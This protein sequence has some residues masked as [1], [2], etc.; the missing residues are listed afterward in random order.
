M[1]GRR[2]EALDMEQK[3][4]A[5]SMY[6]FAAKLWAAAGGTEGNSVVSPF[7]VSEAMGLALTGARGETAA[8]IGRVILPPGVSDA[9]GYFAQ[10]NR[11]LAGAGGAGALKIANALWVNAAGTG[12]REAFAQRVAEVF[13]GMVETTEF[14]EAAVA[15][16]NRWV[17]EKTDGMIE[18]LFTPAMFAGSD[19]VLANVVCFRG[20]WAAPFMADDTWDERFTLRDGRKGVVPTMHRW[21]AWCMWGEWDEGAMLRLPYKG[22]KLEMQ[23][24]V[25]KDGVEL[26]TLERCLGADWAE[27]AKGTTRRKVDIHLPRF[28]VQRAAESL[29]DALQELGI[30]LAFDATAADFGGMGESPHVIEDVV[31]AAV[32]EVDES[33]TKAAA[34]TVMAVPLGA[35]PE[36]DEPRPVFRADR[37]VLGSRWW[38]ACRARCCFLAGGAPG[39]VA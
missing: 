4:M 21:A 14:N 19:S 23:V 3:P 31:H 10:L 22:G 39:W 7:S 30:R 27:W 15:R 12:V 18:K 5:Q 13:G 35:P 34:A 37:P 28:K 25:P 26:S 11:M 20:K 1:R 33:G 17:E 38:T 2:Q 9:A 32:V 16:A 24:I 8:E 29:K 36:F 6:A